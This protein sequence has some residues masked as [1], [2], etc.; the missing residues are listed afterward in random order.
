LFIA[1]AGPLPSFR[2]IGLQRADPVESLL[3]LQEARLEAQ[4]LEFLNSFQEP[5]DR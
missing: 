2:L 3:D 4:A 1:F 5:K